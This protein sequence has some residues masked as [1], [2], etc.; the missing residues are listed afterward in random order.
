[1]EQE[2]YIH[3]LNYIKAEK[4][5]LS[6]LGFYPIKDTRKKYKILHTLSAIFFGFFPVLYN[7]LGLIYGYQHISNL[8]EFSELIG[9]LLTGMSITVKMM[10]LIWYRKNILELEDMLENPITTKLLSEEEEI[11][12]KSKLKFGQMLKKGFK[13]FFVII[14][15]LHTHILY[16]LFKNV[17]PN[18]IVLLMWFPFNVEDYLY[19]VY[20]SEFFIVPML[21]FINSTLDML[22][23]TLMDLC[24]VQFELLKHRLKRFG[25][26]SHEEEGMDDAVVYDKLSK[27]I[28]HQNYVYRFSEIVEE[29]F[30]VSVF[31]QLATTV[32]VLCCAIFKVVITP[33]NSLQFV[34]RAMYSCT[35][36]LEIIFYCCY[37]QKVLDSSSTISE[38]CFMSNWHH[39][40]I[41]VQ[42]NM[43]LL[44]SRANRSVTMQAGGMFP[45]TLETLM[46]IWRSAYSF[47]TFLMQVYK[48]DN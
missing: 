24:S 42:K 41:K 23:V 30:S 28:I 19:E 38:A 21:A 2:R 5:S 36:G 48:E 37:G 18:S 39:C 45:L 32:V 47:L 46:S 1:M 31:C 15:T 10:N 34:V 14:A 16:L 6:F 35:M 22:N 26:I 8:E 7:V 11:V 29:T 40:S 4:K 44:M 25:R 13:I 20:I 27:I 43:V 3:L 9:Y 33:I 12:L 17:D